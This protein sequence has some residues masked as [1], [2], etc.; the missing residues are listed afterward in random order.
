MNNKKKVRINIEVSR[1]KFDEIKKLAEI[2][3]VSTHKELFDNALTLTKWMMKQR[4][5]GKAVGALSKDDQFTELEM[6]ILENAGI[7]NVDL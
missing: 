1:L 4:K 7:S 2:S 3:G 6:P 5:N